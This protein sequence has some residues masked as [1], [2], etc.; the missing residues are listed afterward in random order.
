MF[1][2]EGIHD[3]FDFFLRVKRAGKKIVI[4][5]ELHSNFTV[6][7]V[8][9]DKSL[10]KCRKRCL[11]RYKCYRNNGYSRLYFIECVLM[12]VMKYLVS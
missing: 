6:G 7:G 12:E 5:N 1:R 2:C 8:S 4:Q 3:D 11:D 10:R 9:N